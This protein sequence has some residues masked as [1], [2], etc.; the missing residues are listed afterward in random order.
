MMILVEAII[1]ALINGNIIHIM[2]V[3]LVVR[4]AHHVIMWCHHIL[5]LFINAILVFANAVYAV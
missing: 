4:V 1:I 5:V 2:D 3:I